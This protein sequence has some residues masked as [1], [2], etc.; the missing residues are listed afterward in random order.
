MIAFAEFFACFQAL[1]DNT[2]T[3]PF[4]EITFLG[5]MV[6]KAFIIKGKRWRMGLTK[7]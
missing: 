2:V 3:G 1:L 7:N 4:M 5:Q 6:L